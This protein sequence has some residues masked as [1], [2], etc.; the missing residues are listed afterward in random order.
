MRTQLAAV[1]LA[2][3][4]GHAL[5]ADAP[6]ASLR[7]RAVAVVPGS[8]P[9]VLGVQSGGKSAGKIHPKT[10]LNHEFDTL[11]LTTGKLEFSSDTDPASRI[12]AC[13]LPAGIKSVILVFVPEVPG[14][15]ACKVIAVDDSPK[16]FPYGSVNILNLTSLPVRIEL[17]KKSFDFKAGEIRVI[18]NPPAGPNGASAM[19]A[20]R[21]IDG[22][23]ENFSS[24]AWPH[25]GPK[26][27]LQ[28]L[29]EDPASKQTEVRGIRDVAVPP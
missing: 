25:P 15:P 29:T 8:V 20:A 18:P 4:S 9:D 10:F 2:I 24:G 17:E 3:F 19:K 13:D 22:K 7:I 21:K 27:V 12:G 28:I 6:S 11:P 16:A 23:W 14:K 26:R 1:A 5:A